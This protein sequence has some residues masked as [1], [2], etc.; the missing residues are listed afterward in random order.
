MID[1][2]FKT[3]MCG[4]A[5]VA[6]PF[7]TTMTISEDGRNDDLATTTAA[8]YTSTSV[9][10][11]IYNNIDAIKKIYDAIACI[12][13]YSQEELLELD[14]MLEAKGMDFSLAQAAEETIQ[15]KVLLKN[16][17]N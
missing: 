4:T 12:E 16:Y 15:P 10:L 11:S 14:K 17:T 6:P 8:L 1:F 7:T 2:L 13:S 5:L 9:G 3:A